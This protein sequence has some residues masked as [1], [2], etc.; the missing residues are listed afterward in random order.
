MSPTSALVEMSSTSQ[1]DAF[2]FAKLKGSNYSTWSEHMQAAL[3]SKYLWLIVN[4]T[5]T[6]PTEPPATRP[7]AMS[8][9]E[10]RAKKKDY[11][12]WLLRNEA[13]QGV[14]KGACE[15]SQ[16]PHVKDAMSAK[17]MWATVRATLETEG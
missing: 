10:Y 16:L 15:D 4:G 6:R 17:S 7:A 3:Q 11:L 8:L 2:K 12:D 9:T 1:A 13:A 5:E 14:I